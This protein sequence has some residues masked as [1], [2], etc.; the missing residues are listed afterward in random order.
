METSTKQT[1][2]IQVTRI[3]Y[4]HATITVEAES[5]EEAQELALDQAGD[6]DY[7]EKSSDYV[8]SDAPSEIDFKQANKIIECLGRFFWNF[9]PED[10]TWLKEQPLGKHFYN[11]L[12]G[13]SD[14]YGLSMEAWYKSFHDFTLNQPLRKSIIERAVDRYGKSYDL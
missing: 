6:H 5:Q 11:K 12:Q 3:G 10:I 1:F 14:G 7:N 9:T 2:D 8:L 4:G 13:N